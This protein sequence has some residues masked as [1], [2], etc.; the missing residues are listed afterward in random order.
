MIAL[1]APFATATGLPPELSLTLACGIDFGTS[2]SA[3]GVSDKGKARLLPVQASSTSV[4]TALFYSFEDDT[5]TYGR[6][7]MSRY[8]A[9]EEGRL[10][11]S[12]KSLLGTALFDDV[13]QIKQRRYAYSEIITEF[14]I[15]LRSATAAKSGQMADEVV[16][17]RPAFF[18][19][20]NADADAKAQAQLADA[21]YDAGFQSVEFQ[22]EPI[23]AALAYEQTVSAEEIALVADIGG[24]TSDFSVVRVSPDRA[25]RAD[26]RDDI[27]GYNGVHIGGT[28]FDRQ[29]SLASLMPFLGLGSALKM[30]N[31]TAPSWYFADLATWH[32][33]NTLYDGRVFTEITSVRRDAVEPE[34]FE[35]LLAVLRARKGHDLLGRVE[36]AKIELS[37]GDTA[38]IP[39]R[40]IVEDLSLEIK[41]DAFET[42]ICDHLERIEHRVRD[43]LTVSGL[44]AA[45][46]RTVFLTG[47]SSGIPAVQAAITRAVPGARLVTGDA[48]GSVATGLGIDAERKFGPQRR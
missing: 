14:L 48:F 37:S 5:T 40:D 41:R 9:R 17:G 29:L 22:F 11:R 15:F 7:A 44:K 39:M 43:V 38:T 19:D 23:A 12:I 27:L 2:N 13:T 42:A 46:V 32:R 3:V 18:V 10:L 34:K 26:R 28:D 30:K 36:H 16:M 24:G 31:M 47:G 4:P 25:T 1:S 8:L 20:D 21:A 45:G 35:R 6:D 33:V